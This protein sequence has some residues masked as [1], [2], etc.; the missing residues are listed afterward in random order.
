M[1]AKLP[2]LLI[3]VRS[4]VVGTTSKMSG[5]R[6]FSGIFEGSGV[7]IGTTE[8]SGIITSIIVSGEGFVIVELLEGMIVT[9]MVI[10][11]MF[12]QTLLPW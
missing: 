9:G 1:F 6:L 12:A 2:G 8:I 3:S 5:V 11:P 4:R 7:P 10:S